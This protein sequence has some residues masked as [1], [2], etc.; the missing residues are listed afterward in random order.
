[1]GHRWRNAFYVFIILALGATVSF[2]H[3]LYE[4]KSIKLWC[5]GE[6]RSIHL[7][8]SR[9]STLAKL[10][11]KQ[12]PWRALSEREYEFYDPWR[13]YIVEFDQQGKVSGKSAYRRR[14]HPIS[15]VP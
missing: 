10:R 15:S 3:R 13:R 1:M 9:E 2:A 8:D 4:Q 7:G 12:I 11:E 6:F 5:R 14:G